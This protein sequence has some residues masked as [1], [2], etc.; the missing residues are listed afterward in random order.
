MNS[1]R[2]Y[3]PRKLSW[4]D[5]D[6]QCHKIN[7]DD[8]LSDFSCPIV[9]LGEPGMGKTRLMERLGEF[10]HCRFITAKSFIRQPLDANFGTL[11]LVI[12]GLDEVATL[13]AGDPLHNVLKK[14]ICFGKPSFIIT[15][16]SAE[17][18]GVT[19]RLNI[20]EEYGGT[21]KIFHLK[22]F[23]EQD[24]IEALDSEVGMEKAK[25]AIH[26]LNSN[27]LDTFFQNPLNLEFITTILKKQG[28]LPNTKTELLCRAVK[29]L[30]LESNSS[31]SLS[32]LSRLSEEEAL[33]A[34]GCLMATMLITGNDCISKTQ[35]GEGLISLSDV[36]EFINPTN[37]KAIL[38]SRLFRA[39]NSIPPPDSVCFIPLHRTVAEFLGARWISHQLDN[40]QNKNRASRRFLG[41]ISEKGGI[42]ASLRG[43]HAWLAKFS[44]E[45]LGPMVIERD[46]Y[47]V[48]R[49]A[50]GDH[51]S[52]RQA[53]LII[54]GLKQLVDDDPHFRRDW[55]ESISTKGLA[56]PELTNDIQEVISNNK[57]SLH[58]RDLLLES[59]S[60]QEIASSLKADLE[61]IIF[62]KQRY[63]RE[64]LTAGEAYCRISGYPTDWN[65]F[66]SRLID[67]GD[68]NSTRL[69]ID[70]VSDFGL[71]KV[72]SKVLAKAVVAE[73]GIQK[74]SSNSGSR[75][76]NDGLFILARIIPDHRIAPLLNAL[77]DIISQNQR[78]QWWERGYNENWIMFSYF[79]ERL[80][81]RQLQYDNQPEDSGKI[82]NWISQIWTSTRSDVKDIKTV[83][84]IV[85]ENDDLRLD[86]Q[87]FALF[88]QGTEDKITFLLPGLTAFCNGLS[89]TKHDARIHLE[90]LVDRGD[91]AEEERWKALVSKFMNEKGLIPADIQVIA[92][93]YAKDDKN[94]INFLTRKPEPIQPTESERKYRRLIRDRERRKKKKIQELCELYLQHIEEVREGELRWIYDPARAYLGLFED[95]D[96][97][98][99]PQDRVAELFGNEICKAAINGFEAVLTRSDLPNTSQI[100]SAYTEQHT[101]NYVTPMLVGV[102]QRYLNKQDFKDIPT[103]IISSILIAADYEYSGVMHQFQGLRD[104]L[105]IRLKE[106]DDIYEKH[107]RDKIEPMLVAKSSNIPGLSRFGM[108]EPRSSLFVQFC[109]EWLDKFT[110]LPLSIEKQLADCVIHSSETDRPQAWEELTKIARKRQGK[111]NSDSDEHN[112]WLSVQ[113]LTD[114]QA[115][116]KHIPIITKDNRDFL[117]SL[118]ECV[119]R[120]YDPNARLIP[121][122]IEQLKW[123]FTKF[124]KVW[125]VAKRPSGP[126]FGSKNPWDATE[127]LEWIINRIGSIPSEE[128]V[129]ALEELHNS[130]RDDYKITIKTAITD[131][132]RKRIESN[133]ISPSLT[134]FKAVL[135]DQSPKSAADVQ[136]IILD[137]L[138]ELQK[139]LRG[140]SLDTVNNFYNDDG[141]PRGEEKCRDQMLIAL[142]KIPHSIYVS[143]ETLMPQRKRSDSAF[144]YDDIE[145]PLEAKGQ[146]HKDVWIAA[147]TQLD[148]YYTVSHKSGSK[149]IYVVFWFGNSVPDKNK[150]KPPPKGSR[151]PNSPEE[152]SRLLKSMIP[153]NRRG[154]IEVF[155]LDV[156][157]P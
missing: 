89:I 32:N 53:S 4:I 99:P 47:G 61:K 94:L 8:L 5:Q 7:D 26:I 85:R 20:E 55:Q 11:R 21:P 70:L 136:A 43:F 156:T 115:A 25:D 114:F 9:I 87:R 103:E 116:I 143:S 77:T 18:N 123:I 6:K 86:L 71:E 128:A 48:L 122:T 144:M 10:E 147:Y 96:S 107:L 154:D 31:H 57:Y 64:R 151:V 140:D 65:D 90:E 17:W 102:I 19:S 127:L 59:V 126:H 95:I 121:V 33:D 23:T 35:P 81:S 22:P 108:D 146:W 66:V 155:V 38:G 79:S 149:G 14:L 153:Q 82:W 58:L 41:L 67:M 148:R 63:F 44:P 75:T 50:D 15:C 74:T 93:P 105:E 135:E 49:Y 110:D 118:T 72:C 24:A 137:E 78:E 131:N 56:H 134:A 39:D 76:I 111:S 45:L 106:E 73:S 28:D 98:N 92:K 97:N 62:N 2:N 124:R 104:T 150:L 133:F 37:A 60:G 125:P 157:K 80:I 112:F 84:E 113:F 46:P 91:P 3:I 141:T 83:S 40:N 139:K 51:L 142:G 68:W 119:Y 16:R 54:R 100:A 120:P 109:L 69:A 138:S 13:E 12:D 27:G 145:V 152:M 29:S 1:E 52:Q 88:S 132:R 30:R 101:W 130:H 129:N 42:P 117:W 36:S 34:A